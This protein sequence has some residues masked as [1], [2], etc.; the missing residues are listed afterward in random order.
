MLHDI[1]VAPRQEENVDELENVE[2]I[3]EYKDIKNLTKL[4]EDNEK[5]LYPGCIEFMRLSFLLK[6]FQLKLLVD[7]SISTSQCF[8][9]YFERLFHVGMR[10]Y[11]NHTMSQKNCHD[12]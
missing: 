8:L 4:L 10:A 12:V 6:L 5:D 7:K 9:I 1:F 11:L 3:P 2:V